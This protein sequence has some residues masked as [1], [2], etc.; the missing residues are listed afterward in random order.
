MELRGLS[1][2]GAVLHAA[3]DPC[4]ALSHR[5][6]LLDPVMAA[7][8]TRFGITHTTSTNHLPMT[9]STFKRVCNN[10]A[11]D[12]DMTLDTIDYRWQ[13]NNLTRVHLDSV[14]T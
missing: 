13:R 6:P 2:C 11:H 12:L 14:Q 1:S 5:E 9:R 7:S 8:F 3:H 4:D 10:L